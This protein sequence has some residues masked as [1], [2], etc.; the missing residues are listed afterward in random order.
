MKTEPARLQ[1]EEQGSRFSTSAYSGVYGINK[2]YKITS[3]SKKILK[4]NNSSIE[5]S[6]MRT[7]SFKNLKTS[8]SQ[9]SGYLL[10]KNHSSQQAL[11]DVTSRSEKNTQKNVK[12]NLRLLS[13]RTVY[14]SSKKKSIQPKTLWDIAGY[15]KYDLECNI[16]TFFFYLKI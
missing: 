2:G 10:N 7:A 14:S 11:L 9:R 8:S 15:T 5:N 4:N 3:S 12:E 1:K 6:Q 16:L 13:S